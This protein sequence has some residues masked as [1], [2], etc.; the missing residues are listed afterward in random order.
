M[1]AWIQ[2]HK[3]WLWIGAILLLLAGGRLCLGW[4]LKVALNQRLSRLADY[5]GHIDRVG[6]SLWRGAYQIE[7]MTFLKKNGRLTTPFF[8]APWTDIGVQWGPLLRGQV[9]A[10]VTVRQGQ[11]N[12]V[13]GPSKDDSQFGFGENWLPVL[14]SLVPVDI[15]QLRFQD[16]EIHFTDPAARPPVDLHLQHLDLHAENL[17]SSQEVRGNSLGMVSATAG[18]MTDAQLAVQAHFDRFAKQP[19]FD[20][21]ATILGLKLPELNPF[22]LRYAAIDVQAG[23]LDVYSEAAAAGGNYK[24]YVKPILRG[25]KV[26]KPDEKLRPGMLLKKMLVGLLGWLFKNRQGDLATKFEF[27][28]TF[29]HPQSSTWD[30]FVYL[31]QNAFIKALPHSLE[32]GVKAVAEPGVSGRPSIKP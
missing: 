19:T 13:N 12:F 18:L 24:S 28:G 5:S 10:S 16:G 3:R 21:G 14:E 9:V 8:Y 27:N 11:L 23:S 17:S 1:R 20:Y 26:M 25:L 2:I 32:G 31:F 7:D 30:A 6:L 22:L 15:N 29:A 4:F